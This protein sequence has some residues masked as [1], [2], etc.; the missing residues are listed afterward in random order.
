[1]RRYYRSW[2]QD[3]ALLTRERGQS[4]ERAG[5]TAAFWFAQ[6]SFAGINGEL[7]VL[8]AKIGKD[9][10][11]VNKN[12]QAQHEQILELKERIAALEGK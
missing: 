10:G 7:D 9:F 3:V 1:M 8:L 11:V 6:R 2:K 12:I 4:E 5:A